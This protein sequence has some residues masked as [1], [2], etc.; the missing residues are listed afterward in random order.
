MWCF[1][2]G[3]LADDFS[4][5]FLLDIASAKIPIHSGIYFGEGG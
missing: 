1:W 2:L 5:V 4:E 3:Y